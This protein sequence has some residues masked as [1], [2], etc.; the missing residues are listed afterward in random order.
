MVVIGIDEHKGKPAVAKH[1]Q[2]G[3]LAQGIR[4]RH[5]RERPRHTQH[6]APRAAVVI[7][8]EHLQNR[9]RAQKRGGLGKGEADDVLHAQREQ[10]GRGEHR[11]QPQG[12][13]VPDKQLHDA[14]GHHRAG[15]RQKRHLHI[16][17]PRQR[18]KRRAQPAQR[19]RQ[20]PVDID[21][22]FCGRAA[23]IAHEG[24]QDARVVVDGKA[25]L[26]KPQNEYHHH[27]RHHKGGHKAAE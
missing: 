14:L 27:R 12:F 6:H 23:F 20:K 2:R 10:H 17:E 4:K 18:R 8:T 7:D 3:D 13:V 22:E 16:G 24:A 25:H 15:K 9:R 21:V 1:R 11:A 19:Q 5:Q 26:R